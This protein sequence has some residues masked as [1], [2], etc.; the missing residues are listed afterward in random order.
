MKWIPELVP[1]CLVGI[2]VKPGWA[3]LSEGLQAYKR[4]NYATAL[5]EWQPLAEQGLL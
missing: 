3:G 4:G 2:S 5:R 1:M